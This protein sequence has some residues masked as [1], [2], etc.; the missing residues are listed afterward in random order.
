[1]QFPKL[2]PL[3]SRLAASIAASLTL[4]IL[5]FAFSRPQFAYAFSADSIEHR[6]HNHPFL[7]DLEACAVTLDLEID[8][9]APKDYSET[10]GSDQTLIGRAPDPPVIQNLSNNVPGQLNI[11]L[12]GPTQFWSFPKSELEGP[13]SPDNPILPQSDKLFRDNAH[14]EGEDD[15]RQ[16]N[17]ELRRR[18]NDDRTYYLT[19]NVCDQPFP[20]TSNPDGPPLPLQVHISHDPDNMYPGQNP[21]DGSYLEFATDGY[22]YYSTQTTLDV[23]VGV[24][25]PTDPRFQGQYNY[26]L[27]ISIDKPYAAQEDF[28]NL[29]HLDSDSNAGLFVSNNL[30]DNNTNSAF[31]QAWM[32]SGSPF[33]IFV[34]DQ[35]DVTFSGLKKSF[36][37]LKKHAQIKGNI[38]SLNN[39]DVEAVM[40]TVGGGYPKEQLLVKNLN[41]SSQYYAI[42]ALESNYSDPGSGHVN[43]GGTVWDAILFSTQPGTW[44]LLEIFDYVDFSQQTAT[45]SCCITSTFAMVSIMPFLQIHHSPLTITA[46]RAL[47]TTTHRVFSRISNIL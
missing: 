33:S 3:Q 5:F 41:S 42:I 23:Y 47:M 40:T 35:N 39:T 27:T 12:G 22:F 16:E 2:T 38:K 18:Q 9:E 1:M 17:N 20:T 8:D 25:A 6:D 28:S 13:L 36:C 26:E 15:E 43:G 45:A 32:N 37:G 29:H 34:H 19:L 44:C 11:T 10:A 7:L 30:T 4:L 46:S 21:N 24:N 14:L 31:G